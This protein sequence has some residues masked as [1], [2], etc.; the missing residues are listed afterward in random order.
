M[1]AGV[2]ACGDVRKY[3]CEEEDGELFYLELSSN[4]ATVK[5]WEGEEVASERIELLGENRF[6]GPNG[7]E[8]SPAM[9]GT[10]MVASYQSPDTGRRNSFYAGCKAVE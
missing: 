4:R 9:L 5:T 1:T 2:V 7:W 3:V 8:G 6:Q 10:D